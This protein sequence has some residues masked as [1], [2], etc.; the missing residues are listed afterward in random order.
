[1]QT[2]VRTVVRGGVTR[3]VTWTGRDGGDCAVRVGALTRDGVRVGRRPA[4]DRPGQQVDRRHGA[5]V[6]WGARRFAFNGA[7]G[8]G[9]GPGARSRRTRTSGPRR[10]TYDLP[11]SDRIRQ[12]SYFDLVRRWDGNQAPARAVAP[13]AVGLD[14]A[15]WHQRR[16]HGA[17]PLPERSGAVPKFKACRPEQARFTVTDGLHLQ[18]GRV[19]SPSTGGS[20]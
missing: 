7:Q 10:A 16:P 17:L 8:P 6:R 19:R 2:N 18:A 13:G 3:C 20:A 4:T 12:F 11:R 5:P 9:S 1:M 15:V 14:V